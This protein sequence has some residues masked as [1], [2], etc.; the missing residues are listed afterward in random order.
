MPALTA[1]S[2]LIQDHITALIHDKSIAADLAFYESSDFYDHL[3]RAQAESGHRPAALLETL[4]SLLQNGITLAAMLAVL[5]ADGLYVPL[6]PA[7]PEERRKLLFEDA[8]A[9]VVLTRER[10]HRDS[11][12]IAGMSAEALPTACL[13]C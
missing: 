10:L 2:D 11:A 7:T 3:H 6:D 13:S 9:A 12:L 8:G 5:K 4:G 1:Q